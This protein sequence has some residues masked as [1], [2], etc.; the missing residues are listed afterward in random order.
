[1][2]GYHDPRVI[3]EDKIDIK[4]AARLI[5]VHFTTLIDKIKRGDQTPDGGRAYLGHLHIGGNGS[6]IL[7]SRQA[8]ERYL[9]QINGIAD[10][11]AAVEASPTR[12]KRREKELAGVDRYLDS[13]GI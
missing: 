2:A 3:D 13:V 6:K 1:V 9:R 7:T 5:G 4:G 11:P 10:D 12:S 8:V